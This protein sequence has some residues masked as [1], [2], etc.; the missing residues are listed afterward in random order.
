VEVSIV[1]RTLNEAEWL[2]DAL[3]SVASQ[4][5]N[6]RPVEVIIVDSGSTDATL[7]I[8]QG[9]GARIVTIK[10]SEFTF[11]RSLNVGCEASRGRVIAMISGHC[12]PASTTWLS[13]LI[14]PLGSEG[15]VYTYGKQ[16]GHER[17]KYSEHRLFKKYFPDLNTL[18]QSGFFCNN[19]NSAIFRDVWANNRFDEK[20]TGLEDMEIGKRLVSN[21]QKIGYVADAPVIHIHEESWKKVRIRYEREAIALQAIMPE[22]QVSLLDFIR[23][24]SHGIALDVVAAFQEKRLFKE[25]YS[26][27]MFRTMQFWGTY[28]GNNDHRIMSR[29]RKESYFYPR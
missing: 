25:L 26:I 28:R 5:M 29:A 21:G 19:A 1:I 11:G 13:N 3:E 9:Y 16:V 14:A 22:I 24:A 27:I 20:L 10:K 17:S 8:A 15:I 7:E 4:E 6:G 23:Y 12:I 18:P 2:S